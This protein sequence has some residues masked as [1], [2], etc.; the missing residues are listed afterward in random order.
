MGGWGMG[1]RVRR[2]KERQ[3]KGKVGK[4]RGMM[5]VITPSCLSCLSCPSVWLVCHRS[6]PNRIAHRIRKRYS[7]SRTCPSRSTP[8]T[9]PSSRAPSR[10]TSHQGFEVGAVYQLELTNNLTSLVRDRPPQKAPWHEE[11]AAGVCTTG[12]FSR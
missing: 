11:K 2:G 7:L 4:S 6:A 8:R 1:D 3:G 12:R 10:S 9:S 5:M